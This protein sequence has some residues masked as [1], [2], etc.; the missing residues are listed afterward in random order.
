MDIAQTL[1]AVGSAI[2]TAN[3]L[4]EFIKGAGALRGANDEAIAAAKEQQLQVKQALYAAQETIFAMKDQVAEL[5][6]QVKRLEAQLAQRKEH[7]LQQLGPGA[8]AYVAK[9]AHDA[10]RSGPW[11][12]QPCFEDGKQSVLQLAKPDFG[13]DAFQC[14]RCGAAVRVPNDRRAIIRTARAPN[15]F[16]GF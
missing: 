9:D 4:V 6:D 2:G 7:V 5:T 13:F 12:C 8:F 1:S 3:G 11:L 10:V 14:P 15:R 16:Q